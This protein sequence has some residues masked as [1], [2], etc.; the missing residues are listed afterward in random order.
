MLGR[1]LPLAKLP[2]FGVVIFGEVE[3]RGEREV[4]AVKKSFASII[5]CLGRS[6]VVWVDHRLFGSIIGCL[7]QLTALKSSVELGN[8]MSV[9]TIC[10][11]IKFFYHNL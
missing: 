3:R 11:G 2:R 7:G 8:G 6:S 1:G 10:W 5:G 4:G 9:A